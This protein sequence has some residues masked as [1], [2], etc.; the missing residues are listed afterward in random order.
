PDRDRRGHHLRGGGPGGH[1]R[2]AGGD[3]AVVPAAGGLPGGLRCPGGRTGGPNASDSGVV[4]GCG[5]TS[6]VARPCRS[7][8][9]SR[10]GPGRNLTAGSVRRL[11]RLAREGL[12]G[13]TEVTPQ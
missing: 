12:V 13:T 4:A 6:V 8:S 3:P 9:T 5:S 7:G 2:R 10:T 11:Q 1:L